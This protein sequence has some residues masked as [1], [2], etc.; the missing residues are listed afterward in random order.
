MGTDSGRRTPD[1]GLRTPDSCFRR[2]VGFD[3][4]GDV[5]VGLANHCQQLADGH[6]LVNRHQDLAEHAAAH[7]FHFHI[8]FIGLDFDHGVA[9]GNGVAFLLEPLQ[10]LALRHRIAALGHHYLNGHGEPSLRNWKLE[11]GDRAIGNK[12]IAITRQSAHC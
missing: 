4:R 2:A 8:H 10:D 12:K 6:H 5:L 11:I 3:Q 9:G 7:R 1:S